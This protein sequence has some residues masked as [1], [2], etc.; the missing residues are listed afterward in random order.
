MKDCRKFE[1][2]KQTLLAFLDIIQPAPSGLIL[3]ICVQ[4][5]I[6]AHRCDNKEEVMNSR[7]N[8]EEHGSVRARRGANGINMVL[9]LKTKEVIIKKQH[10]CSALCFIGKRKGV[11]APRLPKSAHHRIP[12]SEGSWQHVRKDISRQT[13]MRLHMSLHSAKGSACALEAVLPDMRLAALNASTIVS[14]WRARVQSE[15]LK[16]YLHAS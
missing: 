7:Q 2:S 12:C 5:Y 6:C 9:I 3:H 16:S 13:L 11:P 14:G 10:S 1:A 15:N 4:K 8:R